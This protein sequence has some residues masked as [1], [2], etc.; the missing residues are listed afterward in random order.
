[1][2]NQLKKNLFQK[3][4]VSRWSIPVFLDPSMDVLFHGKPKNGIDFLVVFFWGGEAG[5]KLKNS[6]EQHFWV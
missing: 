6:K 2:A 1:M 5:S 4:N 3:P